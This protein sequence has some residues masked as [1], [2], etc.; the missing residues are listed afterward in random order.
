[1]NTN[2]L[3]RIAA[4]V[5][6]PA[7]AGMLLALMDGRSLTAH[8]LA[9]AARIT[10][11]TASRHL[12]LM[13]E[14]GLLRVN[15]QG[16][17]RYHQL[18]SAEVA[19][20]L[21]GL[22]QLAVAQQS[23]VAPLVGPRDAALRFARTCYDHLAGRL[24]VAIADRLVEERA[25]LLEGE[26]AVVT[27]RAAAAL[28][29]LGLQDV[30]LREQG[31]AKRPPCRPCL[32]W[33]ERRMHLAGRLGAMLCAHCLQQGWLLQQPRSRALGL[34]PRGA[35]ALRDWFGAQ[36]WQELSEPASLAATR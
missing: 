2:Q 25:V 20:V 30:A 13:V 31:S 16:R 12:G 36:R 21:E 27:D 23:A 17:H 14:G 22:M 7:R 29:S 28:A 34:S 24:A 1:M 19:R 32:D 8:E 33:G 3:A 18:A 11:A 9:T 35:T 26:T 4:L 6:E 15:R 10:P 5:G